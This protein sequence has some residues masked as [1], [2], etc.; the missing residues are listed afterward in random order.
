MEGDVTYEDDVAPVI[1]MVQAALEYHWYD[2]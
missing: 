2:E 1:V